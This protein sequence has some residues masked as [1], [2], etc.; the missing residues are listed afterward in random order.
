MSLI[1]PL[2]AFDSWSRDVSD[3]ETQAISG[4][5]SDE[6]ITGPTAQTAQSIANLRQAIA[7]QLAALDTYI[8]DVSDDYAPVGGIPA[9]SPEYVAGLPLNSPNLQF[10]SVEFPEG[11]SDDHLRKEFTTFDE[12]VNYIN[13]SGNPASFIIWYDQQNN[14]Y[15][16]YFNYGD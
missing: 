8:S 11:L 15:K 9:P 2:E 16:V 3:L 1:N 5:V 14:V 10:L 12:A 4:V 13:G 6:G 7:N